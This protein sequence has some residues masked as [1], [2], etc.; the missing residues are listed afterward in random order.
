MSGDRELLEM[1]A[2][3]AGVEGT[4]FAGYLATHPGHFGI[5]ISPAGHDVWDP[6]ND[7]ADALRLAVK[8]GFWMYI[9][10]PFTSGEPSVVV[11]NDLPG[12]VR[13]LHGADPY[14]AVRRA[15]VRAAAQIGKAMP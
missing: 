4:W 10:K 3:A 15:I 7:D 5:N 1:A 14:A 9:G 8:L 13:E 12:E 2:K 6:M 11:E